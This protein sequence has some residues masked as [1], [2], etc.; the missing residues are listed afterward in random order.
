MTTAPTQLT[1]DMLRDHVKSEKYDTALQQHLLEMI[2]NAPTITQEFVQNLADAIEN[3][4]QQYTASAQ[5]N[6]DQA[7]LL[8]EV[9]DHI[10]LQRETALVDDL[11]DIQ[12]LL[13]AAYPDNK[14]PTF[15]QKP[16]TS[17]AADDQDEIQKLQSYINTLKAEKKAV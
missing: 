6:M 2:D 10:R 13:D 17:Q 7:E 14:T 9:A 3:N 1:H 16:Q 12:N 5:L 15:A 8:D 4:T 11:E